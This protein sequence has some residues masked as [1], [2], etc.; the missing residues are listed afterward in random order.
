MQ[1]V[2]LSADQSG[3]GSTGVYTVDNES[4]P[5]RPPA[6]TTTEQLHDPTGGISYQGYL[7]T[8]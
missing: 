2:A 8:Y 3:L 7:R 1:L 4:G 6:N 5:S